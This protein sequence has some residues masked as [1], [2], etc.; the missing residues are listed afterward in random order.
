MCPPLVEGQ[1]TQFIV[2]ATFAAAA[3]PIATM[4]AAEISEAISTYSMTVAPY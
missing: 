3:M 4:A 1:E 2:F